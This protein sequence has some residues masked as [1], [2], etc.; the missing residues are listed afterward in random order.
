[1]SKSNFNTFVKIHD[2]KSQ[3]KRDNNKYTTD[4]AQYPDIIGQVRIYT[5]YYT[6]QHSNDTLLF[7]PIYKITSAE[8]TSDYSYKQSTRIHRNTFHK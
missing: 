1:M 3:E 7:F 8:C 2:L 5:K 4:D 6:T